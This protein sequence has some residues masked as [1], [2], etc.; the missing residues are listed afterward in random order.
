M[1]S[2]TAAESKSVHQLALDAEVI[3]Q[4]V[5]AL[6]GDEVIRGGRLPSL[7][8][9]TGLLRELN[10]ESRG[11]GVYCV[12]YGMACCIE[13][14]G[15]FRG[16]WLPSLI[17][18]TG[19]LRDLNGEKRG[20]G[21]FQVRCGMAC[22]IEGYEV[23]RGR[24]L[25]I[26]IAIT[27]LLRDLNSEKSRQAECC[28]VSLFRCTGRLLSLYACNSLVDATCCDVKHC[29]V[30]AGY[31]YH[32][33]ADNAPLSAANPT[34]KLHPVAVEQFAAAQGPTTVLKVIAW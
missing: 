34:N 31:V 26:L 12:D 14:D 16:G 24:W 11:S 21:V 23:I 9:V 18:V 19:L 4:L 27:Q 6:A 28:V 8:A 33:P 30:P 22:C 10:G 3:L 15:V 32:L 2:S 13:E 5:A 7:I 29:K 17:A 1:I 20:L 25:L